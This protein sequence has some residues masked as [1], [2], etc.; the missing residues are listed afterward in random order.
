MERRE[1]KATVRLPRE[2]YQQAKRRADKEGQT[3][4]G[5][6]KNLIWKSIE[7]PDL[8]KVPSK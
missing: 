7:D 4:S 2:M 6:V 5:Y 3:F 8:Q 1:V